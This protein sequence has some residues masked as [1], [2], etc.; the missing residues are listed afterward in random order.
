MGMSTLQAACVAGAGPEDTTVD[1]KDG[2]LEGVTF[3]DTSKQRLTL[4]ADAG[5]KGAREAQAQR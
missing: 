1:E 4:P 3:F 5:R 2:R